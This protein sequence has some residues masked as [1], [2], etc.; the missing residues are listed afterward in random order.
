VAIIDFIAPSDTELRETD[1]QQPI[2]ASTEEGLATALN[3]SLSNGIPVAASADL[4]ERFGLFDH[5][6]RSAEVAD[7]LHANVKVGS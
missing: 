7:F 2:E 1:S 5:T 6:D 4:A 3:A